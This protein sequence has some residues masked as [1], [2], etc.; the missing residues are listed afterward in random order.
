M[1]LSKICTWAH[2][3]KVAKS[4]FESRSTGCPRSPGI[5][6]GV[7][8]LFLFSSLGRGGVALNFV[9]HSSWEFLSDQ[10]TRWKESSEGPRAETVYAG[11]FCSLGA[12]GGGLVAHGSISS[13]DQPCPAILPLPPTARS[14]MLK[15]TKNDQN[16]GTAHAFH[17]LLSLPWFSRSGLKIK[18]NNF[19]TEGLRD[20]GKGCPTEKLPFWESL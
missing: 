5:W 1:K 14:L 20:T 9:P 8:F 12:R 4:G 3:K 16:Q 2:S 11:A 6:N 15:I 17:F 7:L 13:P 18:K 10:D 19:P